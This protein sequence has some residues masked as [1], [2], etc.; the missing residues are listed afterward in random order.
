MKL[1]HIFFILNASYDLLGT[2]YSLL[3]KAHFCAIW[4]WGNII[5]KESNIMIFSMAKYV[6][7][8]VYF[9]LSFFSYN[10]IYFR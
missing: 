1:L 6:T 10:Y 3:Y 7:K 5:Q 2:E 4:K 9:L 8:C